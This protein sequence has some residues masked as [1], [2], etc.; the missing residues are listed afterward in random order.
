MLDWHKYQEQP[1]NELHAFEGVDPHVHQDA[2]Q[3]G[4]GDELEDGGELD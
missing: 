1:I 4:H 2:V 3:D